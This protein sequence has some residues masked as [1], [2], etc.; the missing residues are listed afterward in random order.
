MATRVTLTIPEEVT[1]V[2]RAGRIDGLRFF[3]PDG[4]LDRKL[5]TDT[6][7]VLDNYDGKWNRGQKAHV[8]PS[9]AAIDKLASAIGKGEIVREKVLFQ[10]FYT[11][12]TL[13]LELVRFTDIPAT[14]SLI[15]EPSC[16][17]GAL[18]AAYRSLAGSARIDAYDLNPEAVA[19]TNRNVTGVV[20]T[21]Q[22][23]EKVEPAAVYDAILMNP[24]YAGGAY[25]R[26]V[27]HA[28]QFLKPGGVIGA[29]LPDNYQLGETQIDRRFRAFLEGCKELESKKVA[30]GTFKESGTNIATTLVRMVV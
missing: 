26:H 22:D 27:M 25:Q 14:A 30:A 19:N 10:A 11:P 12:M 7:K 2:L 4:Q 24:P 29:I 15:L 1:A 8:F 5:Y 21:C 28:Q 20:A 16:G 9:Q 3:L 18:I 23:F 17:D 13:A 6:N